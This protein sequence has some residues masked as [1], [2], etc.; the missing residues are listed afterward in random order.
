[1]LRLA[2]DLYLFVRSFFF[3]VGPAFTRAL[4]DGYGGLGR[5]R[6]SRRAAQSSRK[7]S[8]AELLRM[9]DWSP[10]KVM[11]RAPSLRAIAPDGT[12]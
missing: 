9:I 3:G 11:R 7:V 4:F 8:L 12:P 1:P 2:A 10:A 5:M 6:A